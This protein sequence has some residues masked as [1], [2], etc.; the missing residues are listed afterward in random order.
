MLSEL[1]SRSLQILMKK[2]RKEV[3]I[4]VDFYENIKERKKEFVKMPAFLI[5]KDKESQLYIK[6]AMVLYK[7]S[8]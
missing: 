7:N 1:I 4:A 8:D 5:G 3:I 2:K 6:S